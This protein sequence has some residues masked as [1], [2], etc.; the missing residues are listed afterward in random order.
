MSVGAPLVLGADS[1]E[2]RATSR[3]GSRVVE[4][5]IRVD[6]VYGAY[7][8]TSPPTWNVD[9]TAKKPATRDFVAPASGLMRSLTRNLLKLQSK[10]GAA[11]R[12]KGEDESET[13]ATKDSIRNVIEEA[14]P[15]LEARQLH[16]LENLA[17]QREDG[18]WG[19]ANIEKWGFGTLQEIQDQHILFKS[20][21]PPQG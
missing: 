6:V 8:W 1:T 21:K 5:E 20:I 14:F 17:A 11:L 3:L 19:F 12:A 18:R 16:A 4:S 10:L 2:G 13:F 7:R 9:F 15:E